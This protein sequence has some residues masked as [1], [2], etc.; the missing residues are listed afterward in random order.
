MNMNAAP[1]SDGLRTAH[2]TGR[3]PL[4]LAGC[5]VHTVAV[6]WIAASL[7]RHLAPFLVFPL[8]VGI[9]VGA[10][11][12]ALARWCGIERPRTLLTSIA[13]AACVA[14]VAQHYFAY[15]H[16]EKALRDNVARRSEAL[17]KF[18]GLAAQM[19]EQPPASFF[20]FLD[21]AAAAG[22]PLPGGIVATGPYAW[23]SW[24]FDGALVLGGALG[25]AWISS[26]NTPRTLDEPPCE[27]RE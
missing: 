16:A 1:A 24:L 18:P 15:L 20:E 23:L 14:V 11:A 8:A 25:V 9:A 19:T 21:S 13:L 5:L 27:R 6:A 26:S 12:I 7:E 2:T 10:G 17:A 3:A 4:W 22:R